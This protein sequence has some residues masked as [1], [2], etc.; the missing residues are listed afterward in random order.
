MNTNGTN[1]KFVEYQGFKKILIDE[2]EG[3]DE[4]IVAGGGVDRHLKDVVAGNDIVPIVPL[5]SKNTTNDEDL[6]DFFN[7]ISALSLKDSN[8]VA[9]ATE[10]IFNEEPLL[11]KESTVITSRIKH[12]EQVREQLL[13]SC[14]QQKKTLIQ[15]KNWSLISTANDAQINWQTF[16]QS[17]TFTEQSH[18]II[19]ISKSIMSESKK[20]YFGLK[21]KKEVK[22][23][24][25]KLEKP[26]SIPVD[27]A[28]KMN[29]V[30][31]VMLAILDTNVLITP[32]EF[33]AVKNLL[34]EIPG[35]H[36]IFSINF[37]DNVVFFLRFLTFHGLDFIS[38]VSP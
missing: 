23:P 11:V 1:R 8:D 30:E 28:R 27:D 34:N 3:K 13:S 31:H 36:E 24:E 16:Q 35:N 14:S 7:Q 25:G 12:E 2:E 15:P 10:N 6:D 21:K 38:L 29:I 37:C 5:E 18:P 17:T 20:I 26:I 33:A 32:N 19:D 4:H 22:V 9:L